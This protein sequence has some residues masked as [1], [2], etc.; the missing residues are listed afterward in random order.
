MSL[1]DSLGIGTAKSICTSWCG[2][3]SDGKLP[4]SDL[5]IRVLK[6]Y[7]GLYTVCSSPLGALLFF[8]YV[9]TRLDWLV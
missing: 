1:L 6:F 3:C 9:G 5:G 2:S 7:F 4:R 8:V